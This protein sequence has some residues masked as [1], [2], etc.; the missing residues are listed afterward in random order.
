VRPR[1]R[2][3]KVPGSEHCRAS[4]LSEGASEGASEGG[5]SVMQRHDHAFLPAPPTAV[6]GSYGG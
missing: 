4:S 2:Q 6:A 5:E 1:E 3:A